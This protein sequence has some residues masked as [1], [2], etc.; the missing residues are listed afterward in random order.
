MVRYLIRDKNIV[1]H[2]R[3]YTV[4]YFLFVGLVKKL[5]TLCYLENAI[6]RF[7][8]LFELS[9]YIVLLRQYF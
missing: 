3:P 5:Y 1:I 2:D 7:L 6:Y 4:L 8:W 9:K